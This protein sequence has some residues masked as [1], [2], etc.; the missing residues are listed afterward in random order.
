MQIEIDGGEDDTLIRNST[1]IIDELNSS[2]QRDR[3]KFTD[4]TVDKSSFY[5]LKEPEAMDRTGWMGPSRGRIRAQ[6]SVPE[7]SLD[8]FSYLTNYLARSC[9]I[10]DV[11]GSILTTMRLA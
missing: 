4:P 10:A 1:Q 5:L 7:F 2:C 11:T 9:R 3:M 6:V 8:L